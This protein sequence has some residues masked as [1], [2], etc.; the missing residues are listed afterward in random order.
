MAFAMETN[1]TEVPAKAR[2][3]RF[4]AEYDQKILR[5]AEQCR[6]PGGIEC[7]PK[8]WRTKLSTPSSLQEPSTN[9]QTKPVAGAP[10]GRF[11]DVH[12]EIEQLAAT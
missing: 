12:R 1:D 3:R 5:E 10:H 7:G 4:T 9:R 8:S 2:R 6:K 11:S